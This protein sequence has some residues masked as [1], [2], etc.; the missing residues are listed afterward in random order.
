MT[1]TCARIVRPALFLWFIATVAGCVLN[2]L[3]VPVTY[4]TA[5][6]VALVPGASLVHVDVVG[7]DQRTD[8]ASVGQYG[9]QPIVPSNSVID[10]ARD[11][12]QSEL[13][14]RGFVIDS[15]PTSTVVRVQVQRLSGHFFSSLIFSSYTAEL[16]MHVEVQ[17]AGKAITYSQSFDETD[18]YHPSAFASVS[19]DFGAALGG[20]LQKGVAKLFDDPAFMAALIAKR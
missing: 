16:I 9:P 13:R 7:E 11:A 12:V 14:A 19:D 6:N 4:Q 8:K 20:A 2:P 3:S 15:A 5:S 1:P 17:P 18:T 10:M